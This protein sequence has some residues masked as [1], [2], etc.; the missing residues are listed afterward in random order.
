MSCNKLLYAIGKKVR[1]GRKETHNMNNPNN[2]NKLIGFWVWE[3][4]EGR[5]WSCIVIVIVKYVRKKSLEKRWMHPENKTRLLCFLYFS[6]GMNGLAQ[7]RNMVH[8]NIHLFQMHIIWRN[9]NEACDAICKHAILHP[10]TS[11]MTIK[12]QRNKWKDDIGGAHQRV[13]II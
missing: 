2:N 4:I 11:R 1:Q 3:F 9:F 8:N 10:Q 13:I 5:F 7:I 12:L 6:T